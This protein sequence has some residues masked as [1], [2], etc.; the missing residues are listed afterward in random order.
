MS[1]SGSPYCGGGAAGF[2]RGSLGICKFP[3]GVRRIACSGRDIVVDGRG[4]PMAA[5]SRQDVVSTGIPMP[6]SASPAFTARVV[7]W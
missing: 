6:T 2:T 4:M 3:P 1:L 5:A 7:S